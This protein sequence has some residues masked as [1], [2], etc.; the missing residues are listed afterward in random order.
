MGNA[1][2]PKVNIPEEGEK[3]S[4]TWSHPNYFGVEWGF[5][6]LRNLW[7]K[8]SVTAKPVCS[9]SSLQALLILAFLFEFLSSALDLKAEYLFF[10]SPN[11]CNMV[12]VQC[13]VSFKCTT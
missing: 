8:P 4:L 3:W 11:Y 1:E 9:P 7:N 13:Y 12:D 2:L 10:F 6:V 5:L